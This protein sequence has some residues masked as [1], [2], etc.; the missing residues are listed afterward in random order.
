M[1]IYLQINGWNI[2][3]IKSITF[4]AKKVHLGQIVLT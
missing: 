4:G 1:R 3:Y 2:V